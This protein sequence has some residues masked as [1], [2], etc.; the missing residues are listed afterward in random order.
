MTTLQEL[1]ERVRQ[2]A[3]IPGDDEYVDDDVLTTW[4]N[5]AYGEFH[6]L[7][8]AQYQDYLTRRVNLTLTGSL[9]TMDDSWL[10]VRL[11]QKQ[12]AAGSFTTIPKVSLQEDGTGA[13]SNAAL[14]WSPSNHSYSIFGRTLEFYPEGVAPGAVRVHYVERFQPLVSGSNDTLP[15]TFSQN[16]W[17][18]FIVFGAAV[19]VK[20]KED[21]DASFMVA[22]KQ[23]VKDRLQSALANYDASGFERVEGLG[24]DWGWN[25]FYSGR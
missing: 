19:K 24:P 5:D 22:Q 6:D 2:V 9:A 11:V 3:D 12:V 23:M 14:P 7:F 15:T 4:I 20:A 8:V 21:Y 13:L 16:R 10:K 18:D 25:V 1:I 17:D